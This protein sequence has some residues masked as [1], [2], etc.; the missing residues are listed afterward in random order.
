MKTIKCDGC[1]EPLR[2]R[3]IVLAALE[4]AVE[5]ERR[6]D[7]RRRSAKSA[8][9]SAECEYDQAHI[10]SQAA[11]SV[12]GGLTRELLLVMRTANGIGDDERTPG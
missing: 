1:G 7:D 2:E 8:L 9:R 10:D 5:V 4:A 11:S 12:V 6:A 3:A